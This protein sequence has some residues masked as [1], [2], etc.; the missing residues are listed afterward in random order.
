VSKSAPW[1]AVAIDWQDSSMFDDAGEGVRLAWLSLMCL[2]KGQGRAGKVRF[3]L[4]T[5]AAFYRAKV[6]DVTDMLERAKR[7]KA[8]DFDGETVTLLN[9]RE[10][11]DPKLRSVNQAESVVTKRD[12]EFSKRRCSFV[13]PIID[14]IRLYCYERKNRVDYEKFFDHYTA[15]GWRQSNGLPIQDWK[16]AVRTWEKNGR[17]GLTSQRTGGSPMTSK[18][19]NPRM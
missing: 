5:F 3:K 7:H 4:I 17:Q 15:N 18:T 14:E 13:P 16:A 11:Q 1:I 2:V 8:I 9:W 6:D 10:Y 19:Y 12:K